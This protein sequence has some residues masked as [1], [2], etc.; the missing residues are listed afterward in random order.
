MSSTDFIPL[1]SAFELNDAQIESLRTL[2]VH[3]AAMH[4]LEFIPGTHAHLTIH[5]TGKE[6]SQH[7][8]DDIIIP[9]YQEESVP[10][11]PFHIKVLPIAH[12]FGRDE[13]LLV[14]ELEI[15]PEVKA[16]AEKV[17]RDVCVLDPTIRPPDFLEFTPHLTIGELKTND[18]MLKNAFVECFTSRLPQTLPPH[19]VDEII[20]LT[21][22]NP[23][24]GYSEYTHIKL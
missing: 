10:L 11:H 18:S 24:T 2:A 16:F 17:R 23:A 14:L 4:G 3:C 21:K 13:N 5:Y 1:F 20:F 6:V 9:L 22:L 19:Y 7:Q 12:M 8:R 15:P